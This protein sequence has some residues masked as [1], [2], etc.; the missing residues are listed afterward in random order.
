VFKA[1]PAGGPSLIQ[2]CGT[3]M[4]TDSGQGGGGPSYSFEAGK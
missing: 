1:T 2:L 4:L 3:L